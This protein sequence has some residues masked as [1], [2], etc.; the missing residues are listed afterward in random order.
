MS[1]SEHA[2]VLGGG[3]GGLAVALRL[4]ALGFRVTIIERNDQLGG[5][6]HQI[7]TANGFFYDAGPTVITAPYLFDELFSLFGVSA[8]D[9][10]TLLP[11]DPWYR[12]SFP[13]G[14]EFDYREAA[15]F[16]EQITRLSRSDGDGY[17]RYRAYA[18]KIFERGYGDLADAPFLGIW[19]TLR[20]APFMARTGSVRSLYH[21]VSQFIRDEHIRQALSIPSL[22]V[23]G[24]PLQTPA[25]YCLIHELEQ[26]WGV[27]FAQGGTYS[28]VAALQQL[29]GEQGADIRLNTSVDEVILKNDKVSAVATSKGEI[30]NTDLVVSNL[31]PGYLYGSL[32]PD[33]I[34]RLW[35]YRIPAGQWSFGLFV[36]F[37]STD[38]RYD[39]LEHHTI[40]LDGEFK[41]V[42]RQL[43]VSGDISETPN[44]YLHR[45]TAT[46]PA[47]APP[48]K[49]SF[50]VLAPV[51]NLK[52]CPVSWARIEQMFTE[53]ILKTLEQRL[54]PGLSTHLVESFAMTPD[55]FKSRYCSLFGAG[56]SFAPLLIQSASFRFPNKVKGLRNLYL[57][58]AGVHPGA[59]VPGVLNSAKVVE[60]IIRKD[61]G[62]SCLEP[63]A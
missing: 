3:F 7:R 49:D 42:L 54:M 57:T 58:G 30:I 61:Y 39:N 23:G 19:D 47:M 53:R 26:R 40:I 28:L 38:C 18:K 62:L 6:A 43:T 33:R 12:F 2:V 25:I 16:R 17:D 4:L 51:P 22:L 20:H 9:Y 31:D 44:L 50:Y 24:S 8:R 10:F 11:V 41:A 46:D 45:P 13:D 21:Q 56:F 34:T 15:R 55:T 52:D 37:F 48:G 32:L 29:L 60:N 35:K 1:R 59:G 5:R 36:L 14:V 27:W 63:A